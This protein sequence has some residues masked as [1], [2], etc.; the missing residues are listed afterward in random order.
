MVKATKA[1]GQTPSNHGWFR[2]PR[3]IPIFH[4]LKWA[5]AVRGSGE[6]KSGTA[7]RGRP[8]CQ[9]GWAAAPMET[10]YDIT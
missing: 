3:V 6:M 9:M 7:C 2:L 10:A 4:A 5:K 8:E 1:P